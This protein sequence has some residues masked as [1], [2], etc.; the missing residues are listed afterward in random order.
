MRQWSW[1]ANAPFVS[2]VTIQT[3]FGTNPA[4]DLF[5]FTSTG[6]TVTITGNSATDTIN[7]DIAALTLAS[8]NIFVGNA[9][10]IATAVSV[11]GDISITNTGVT[12]ISSGVIV[13][14][15]I[16]AS[17]A[18][19]AT[20]IADGSVTSAEFQFIN[21]LSSNAQTQIDS[22][23][24]LA[25]PALTGVPTSPTASQGNNSTQIAT[26]AYVDTGLATK[27][28][29]ASNNTLSGINNVTG[30]LH[31][32]TATLT[33]AANIS[34]NLTGAQNAVVTLGGNRTLDNP[35]NIK[36]GANYV[37]KVI[38]DGTGSRTLAFGNLYKFP[39]GAVPTLTPTANAVDILTFWSDG[40]NL[41]G[42]TSRNFS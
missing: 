31:F 38:Q 29:L 32:T 40:T 11:T 10:N 36:S 14:A 7:F 41:Y 30:Q 23:A 25:S 18:I 17:A 35:T 6:G 13:N 33:D 42:V 15:D 24:P 4:G 5:T 2:S 22:K 37:L 26:T 1:I 16:N 8:A 9:S 20:K 34:W 21:T 39:G 3:P 19:D 27:A 12:A 28:S